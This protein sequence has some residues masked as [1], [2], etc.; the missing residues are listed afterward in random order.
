[1]VWEKKR[2]LRGRDEK[3]IENWM[4]GKEDEMEAQKR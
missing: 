4:E 1:M 2:N 3:I